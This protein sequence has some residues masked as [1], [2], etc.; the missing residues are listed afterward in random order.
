MRVIV[1]QKILF[2]FN[3]FLIA[4]LFIFLHSMNLIAAEV[5]VITPVAKYAEGSG[6]PVRIDADGAGRLYV[7]KSGSG[8]DVYANNGAY[9]Y[10]IAGVAAPI[11]VGV[12]PGGRI[13]ISDE[14]TGSVGVYSEG[15][16]PVLNS[17]G[18][19]LK[20]GRGNREFGYPNDIATSSDGRVYVTDG[21]GDMVKV[22]DA[23]GA[24]LFSFGRGE[25]DFP[26][27]IVVD[28]AGGHLFVADYMHRY[29][30]VYALSGLSG[31]SVSDPKLNVYAGGKWFGNRQK[32]AGMFHMAQGL[33]VDADRLYI[34]D[35]YNDFIA[36]VEKPV[37]V[38][39]AGGVETCHKGFLAHI[40]YYGSYG[41]A[42]GSMNDPMDAVMDSGGKL[43]VTNKLNKRI[44]VLGIDV[45]SGLE[46]SPA[47]LELEAVTDGAVVSG[48]VQITGSGSDTGWTGEVAAAEAQW[49]S[50]SSY[51]GT[52]LPSSVSVRVDPAGLGGG[53]YSWPV[54]FRS[55]G[56]LESVLTVRVIVTEP[57]YTMSASPDSL[58]FVH[59]KNAAEL[60]SGT[61]T[62]SSVPDGLS[63]S[64]A[65]TEG[66]IA[67][68]ADSGVTNGT[69]GVSLTEAVN[70]LDVGVV[71]E[72][73]IQLTA[74]GSEGLEIPVSVEVVLQGSVSVSTNLAEAGYELT[75][76]GGYSYTGSGLSWSDEEAPEGDYT[77]TYTDVSGY[78]TP[79]QETKHLA[80]G[81][82]IEFLGNY[83]KGKS[84]VT[85][86]DG[87]YEMPDNTIRIYDAG[88][89]LQNEIKV[90]RYMSGGVDT[91]V[92]DIDGDGINELVAGTNRYG[93]LGVFD[94]ASGE[95]LLRENALGWG[96]VRVTAGDIDGDGDAEIV[97][98]GKRDR[99]KVY[100]YQEGGLQET[101]IDYL[102]YGYQGRSDL[103]VGLGDIDGDGSVELVSVAGVNKMIEEEREI[104]Y[105]GWWVYRYTVR[106]RVELPLLK[107]WDIDLSGGAGSWSVVLREEIELEGEPW[108]GKKIRAMAVGDIDGDGS[109]EVVLSSETDAG[110][111]RYAGLA[112]ESITSGELIRDIG[113]GDVTRDGR[114][115]YRLWRRDDKDVP[116]GGRYRQ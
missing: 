86:H 51:S 85:S 57:S 12:G 9:L 13:Y 99:I 83:Y 82:E 94:E 92:G 89:V 44:E 34:V 100:D 18:S 111:L 78:G 108:Q 55:N 87:G 68:G 106:T 27:G 104:T 15:G 63:W 88:G 45:Y 72:G 62:I 109:A 5:P 37:C 42:L 105:G 60:P 76:P 8:V 70:T 46:V 22:Y 91:A 31:T 66:W 54:V 73:L 80:S 29:I 79:A 32:I 115:S 103:L 90:F 21:Y 39:D 49:L 43:F 50:L 47:V 33:A 40:G 17:D 81:A 77:I 41:S 112:V 98:S 71:H 52:V 2:N 7:S 67:L 69:L 24:K 116:S 56:G 107:V 101:G 75:G 48:A 53:E 4:G 113:L 30:K 20:L 58:S 114:D 110:L 97:A 96:G 74:A 35:S 93:Y 14:S 16:S 1:K 23:N 3:I 28:E 61:V 25:L 95:E 26:T 59:K 38:T 11:G 6:A 19:Q 10:S 102:G 36:V 84:I 65:A 64:G